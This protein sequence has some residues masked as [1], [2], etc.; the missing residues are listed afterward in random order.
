ME[1][2][3]EEAEGKEKEG[4][5]EDGEKIEET[6]NSGERGKRGRRGD[7]EGKRGGQDGG[8]GG[9][10]RVGGAGGGGEGDGRRK[11]NIKDNEQGLSHDLTQPKVNT[12][13]CK[14]SKLVGRQ[15]TQKQ[16][17]VHV[18]Q[19]KKIFTREGEKDGRGGGGR[20]EIITLGEEREITAVKR[21]QK[22]E[23]FEYMEKKEKDTAKPPEIHSSVQTR[24]DAHSSRVSNLIRRIQ[25][26]QESTRDPHINERDASSLPECTKCE[27]MS[28]ERDS[29]PFSLSNPA[30]RPVLAPKPKSSHL[31]GRM[32]RKE[33]TEVMDRREEEEDEKEKEEKIRICRRNDEDDNEKRMT[34]YRREGSR[35]DP[36]HRLARER[37][38]GSWGGERGEEERERSE[39]VSKNGGED[40]RD[41]V[42]VRGASDTGRGQLDNKWISPTVNFKTKTHKNPSSGQYT[43]NIKYSTTT[44][45]QD[46]PNL[47]SV[48]PQLPVFAVGTGKKHSESCDTQRKQEVASK[49]PL[50]PATQVV[51]GSS[52][53]TSDPI[54]WQLLNELQDQASES[55]YYRLL[56]VESGASG[57]EIAR[58]RRE[59][60]R[61]LHPD[62]YGNDPMKKEM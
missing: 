58:A 47:P 1:D 20:G 57:E 4:G 42:R 39:D 62:H 40:G 43:N 59:Q 30:A 14:P 27:N 28:Q 37:R 19:V 54:I 22:K 38:G 24:T 3:E 26:T 56:G 41:G 15:Y 49:L 5:K 61:Q 46:H 8:C 55:D 11:G 36:T 29:I 32:C 9:G 23:R 16:G 25:T 7:G 53:E 21:R 45:S 34:M 10:R 44:T 35:G 6:S 2:E 18:S 13:V 60:S 50:F 48:L 17:G 33:E 52:A 51:G 31:R 12:Q